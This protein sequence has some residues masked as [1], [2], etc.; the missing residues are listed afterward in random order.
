MKKAN[1]VYRLQIIKEVATR[2]Q[3]EGS[4]DPM[5]NHI[6]QLLE[7]RAADSNSEENHLFSGNHFDDQ[8]GGWVSNFWSAK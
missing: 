5:A 3:L 1:G 6:H 2:K 7:S 8:A 4:K